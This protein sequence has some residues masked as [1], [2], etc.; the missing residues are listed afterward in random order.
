MRLSNC[1]GNEKK[2]GFMHIKEQWKRGSIMQNGCK[3]STSTKGDNNA[4]KN[5]NWKFIFKITS[6]TTFFFNL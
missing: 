2:D 1:K 6:K 3:I 4:L 5:N